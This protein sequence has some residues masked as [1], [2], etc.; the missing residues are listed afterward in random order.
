MAEIS[1]LTQNHYVFEVSLK[2]NDIPSYKEYPFSLP[3]ISNLHEIKLHPKVTFFIGEN[4][5]G[6]STLVEAIAIAFGF[7]PE[8]G[9]KHFSFSTRESHSELYK[10]I[11][12]RKGVK[13]PRDSYFLR[14]ESFYNV[15][16]NIEDLGVGAVYGERSLHAQ[17]HGESFMSLFLNRFL[18]KGFYILDEPEAALSPMRQLSLISRLHELVSNNS[19]FI[20][21][22]HSPLLLAYPDSYI[23]NID[24]NGI[25]KVS[26][27]QTDHFM[28]TKSFV[29][30][31]KGML[32]ELT[33][34]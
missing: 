7:N 2:R 31:Y 25:K 26:Y 9:S 11:V 13:R 21:A 3:A 27:E 30:N 5:A 12:L 29:N 10:Y 19:Q 33:K 28:I 6:K 23:Y 34:D 4:G 15:A 14:A 1:S 18:G 22:T 32:N 8:G 17:S 24:D 20:I 16:T